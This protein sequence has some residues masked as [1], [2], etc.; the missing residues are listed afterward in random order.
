MDP[1]PALARTAALCAHDDDA[2]AQWACELTGAAR[3]ADAQDLGEGVASV[4]LAVSLMRG[5][6][7]AVRTR[8]PR[9]AARAAGLRALSSTHID[10][11]DD[12]V[13]AWRGQ[14][15]IHLPGGLASRVGRGERAQI[16][17][18]AHPAGEDG[19][20]S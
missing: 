18:R 6:P 13:V 12:L 19:H 10:D 16:I 4:A 9:E 3:V 7:R 8:T 2:L 1:V 17:L 15:P 14:G 11:L 20:Q 5:A